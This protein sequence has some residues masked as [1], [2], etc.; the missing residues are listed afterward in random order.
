MDRIRFLLNA[1]DF[2]WIKMD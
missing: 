2:Q 1:S